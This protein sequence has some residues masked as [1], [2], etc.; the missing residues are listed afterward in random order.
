MSEY[1]TVSES[2]SSDHHGSGEAYISAQALVFSD[3]GREIAATTG[4]LP[5]LP[6]VRV[7]D[8]FYPEIEEYARAV[9][10]ILGTDVRVLRCLDRGSAEDGRPR[11]YSLVLS[12]G[13]DDLGGGFCWCDI[14]ELSS[15]TDPEDS[16]VALVQR[17]CER[18]SSGP[19]EGASVP[20]EWRG[21]WG[22]DVRE[23]VREQVKSHFSA[24]Q[25]T[26]TPI[27]SWSISSVV[28]IDVD[29]SAGSHRLFFKASPK[30][31]SKEV[32]ITDIVAKRFPEISP[33]LVAVDREWGWMLMEDLGDLTLGDADSV[34]IWC[35]AMRALAKVQIGFLG[36]TSLLE[37]LGLERR[38][39]SAIGSTLVEWMQDAVGLGLDYEAE[40]TGK[41]LERLV[42]H[43]GLVDELCAKV[44]S[45]GLPSTLDHGD[46]DAGNI[47]VRDGKPVIMDWSDSSISN[48]LFAPAL[49]SQVSRNSELWGAFL[50]EWTHVASIDQLEDA[51]EASKPLAALERA[52]HYRRNIVAHLDSPSVDRRVLESYIPDLLNLAATELVQH[53]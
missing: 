37:R 46:L 20:W 43:V 53:G 9:A 48:P 1:V 29:S 32:A 30:F 13:C 39:T 12:D 17:E 50:E 2:S 38:S 52:F 11:L 8:R 23:W 18:V 16:Q 47:F 44:D 10:H 41:A 5:A 15:L 42:P 35:E 34:D 31:F 3:D 4:D 33:A 25:A 51:F 14:T 45:L 28:R 22:D 27:R 24:E 21:S 7:R 6:E 26:L 40:R 19:S 49:I 36:D